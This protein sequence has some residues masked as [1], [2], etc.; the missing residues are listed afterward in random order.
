MLQDA[1][2]IELIREMRQSNSSNE[3]RI[4]EHQRQHARG[5]PHVQGD[6]LLRRRSRR[7]HRS[8]PAGVVAV[9]HDMTKE[10]EVAEMKNDFV[11]NV[12]HELRTPLASIKAYVEMLIDGEAED[13]RTKREF[14]EVIQN[15]ANRLS[16]L[17]DD[18]L[19][20]SPDRVRAGEGEQAAAEPGGD[21]QG[22]GRGHHAA[23]QAEEHHR[24]TRA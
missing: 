21:H 19:N 11:S 8:Q 20:I 16:R 12:S 7:P 17:I 15:E 23:G 4:V 14:Y 5:R 9:L 13:E 24:S 1:K 6:A 3:R 18:I 22:S 2:L 10:K